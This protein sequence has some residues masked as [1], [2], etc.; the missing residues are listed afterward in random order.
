MLPELYLEKPGE[1]GIASIR[2]KMQEYLENGILE[3][4]GC[5]FVLVE[6]IA[7]GRSRKGLVLALDLEHY[8]YNKGST[9]LIRASEGT[10]VERIPPRQ[11]IR[12]G[13]P[14]EMPHII[15]LIDDPER[16]L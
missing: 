14:I 10:I 8:D 3:E 16:R 11:K 5:G 9:T 4:K 7:N 1:G 2:A 13:A 12:R 6:R 15:V